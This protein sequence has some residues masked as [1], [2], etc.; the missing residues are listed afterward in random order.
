LH[1]EARISSNSGIV[2]LLVLL[3][4][5]STNTPDL[6]LVGEG[7]RA[8]MLSRTAHERRQLEYVDLKGVDELRFQIQERNTNTHTSTALA[9]P[10]R[11]ATF[12]TTTGI[13]P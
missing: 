8:G 1:I 9:V 3:F 4:L 10:R 6:G 13:K 7:R 12:L 11:K 2:I 5:V